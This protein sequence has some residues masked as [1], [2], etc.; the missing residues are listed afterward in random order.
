M[1][2]PPKLS[3]DHVSARLRDLPG[4]S[5]KAGK[6]HRE[7]TFPDFVA[8]FGFMTQVA[9]A[10]E[11]LEHHPEWFNVWNRVTVDLNT[12]DAGGLTEL[13]F[14]LA[15]RMNELAAAAPLRRLPD[16]PDVS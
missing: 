8:A 7:F 16:L 2:A 12:H 14:S 3:A 6:L 11:A 1:P 10:A 9:H 13:D 15:E 4:W 5:L